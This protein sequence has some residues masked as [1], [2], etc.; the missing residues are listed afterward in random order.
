M[1]KFSPIMGLSALILFA[2]SCKKDLQSDDLPNSALAYSARHGEK[3]PD[4]TFYAL[5]EGNKLDKFSMDNNVDLIASATIT[6]LGTSEKIL[7]IDF[8]PAT[9]QLYGLG[10]SSRI[11]V[12]D[13][14]SGMARAIG[15]GP[16]TPLLAG[17]IAGFDFNPTVDR[18]RV[19]TSTGQN[20]RINPETGTVA[21]IDGNINGAPN[22]M[23]TSVAYSN[24][25]AGAATTTLY[26]IDVKTDKLY[27]QNPPNNGTL[28]EIGSLNINLEGEG[29]FD[30]A[31]PTASDNAYSS[32]KNSGYSE[33]TALAIYQVNRKSTL[34]SIDLN[35]GKAKKI[36]KF[37]RSTMY[38]GIAIATLPVAYAISATDLVIF[39]P[40]RTSNT[41]AKP[42]TGLQSGEK[43]VGIDFRPVN[44]Q[45]YGLGSN[46]RLYT[47][48]ASSGAASFVAALSTPLMGTSFGVDFN[49]V[50]DRIR[51]VSNSGQNLRVNPKDGM[52]TVDGSLNPGTPSV[53]AA[54]YANNFAGTTTTTLYVIDAA[55]DKLYIQNPPNAGALSVV[56]DLGI[57]VDANNGFDIGGT[58]NMAYGLFTVSGKT[59]IYNIDINNGRAKAGGDLPG[60][61]AGF[62][63]G[64]GF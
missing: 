26:D 25:V 60:Q 55:K 34:F 4:V 14:K 44:G 42:I 43:L 36:D 63:L 2:S 7:A 12:I 3:D 62:T 46:S 24:N 37:N 56:G 13:P 29:G 51:I 16:F 27:R 38:Y 23:V 58:S 19:V 22:A 49:P 21:A 39:N 45:L 17:T 8:R 64:L 33:N 31:P 9:G 30:I 32:S 47:I 50:V 6:G 41:I 11:Y 59:R 40:N 53:S 1:K 52:T 10:S 35:T 5:G 15:S 20:L 28:E 18:I 54:A 57:N 61:I 48:N